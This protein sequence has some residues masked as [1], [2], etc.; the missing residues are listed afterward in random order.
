MDVEFLVVN[1]RHGNRVRVVEV[2]RVAAGVG[3]VRVNIRVIRVFIASCPAV[4]KVG[5]GG[6][7]LKINEERQ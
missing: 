7:R 6:E 1:L 2:E 3:L 5:V 4:R